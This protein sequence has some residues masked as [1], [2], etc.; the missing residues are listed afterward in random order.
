MDG[1]YLVYPL[2]FITAMVYALRVS[3][4]LQCLIVIR[5]FTHS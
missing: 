1:G 4:L 5:N 3:V 2:P